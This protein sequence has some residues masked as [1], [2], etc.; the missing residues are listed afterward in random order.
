MCNC[1]GDSEAAAVE[2]ERI[3]N[4]AEYLGNHPSSEFCDNRPD[5]S[6]NELLFLQC[7]RPQNIRKALER[8]SQE[9]L[10][11]EM[12]DRRKQPS[13][14]EILFKICRTQPP[15]RLVNLKEMG[16]CLE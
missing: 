10:K 5:K 3:G 15:A 6:G 13:Q 9:E 4:P 14:L 16:C 12:A 7:S 11:A 2:I 1:A 8:L